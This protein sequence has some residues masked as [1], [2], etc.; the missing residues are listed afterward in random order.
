M[1][2]D[3]IKTRSA[4]KGFSFKSTTSVSRKFNFTKETAKKIVTP[5]RMSIID[6]ELEPNDTF[7]DNELKCLASPLK[8]KSN[9]NYK[10]IDFKEA[11]DVV[12]NVIKKQEDAFESFS[13]IHKENTNELR[14]LLNS[15]IIKAG[16]E[17]VGGKF[18]TTPSSGKKDNLRKKVLSKSL[19]NEIQSPR[20]RSAMSLY[21]SLRS[22]NPV[23]E[24]PKL[25]RQVRD[26]SPVKVLSDALMQQCLILQGTPVRK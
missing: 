18:I 12:E 5:S 2:E 8:V 10:V 23:L 22:N 17:N 11:I 16:K 15:L 9:K 6:E 25:N 14:L 24:T 3:L 21:N 7:T 1:E 13:R 26:E 4:L 19:K 20:T